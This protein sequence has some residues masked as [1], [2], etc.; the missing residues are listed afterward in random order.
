[1]TERSL[2]QWI[3][4]RRRGRKLKQFGKEIAFEDVRSQIGKGGDQLLPVF[5][6]EELK[7]SGKEM[8]EYR[9]GFQARISPPRQSVS[10]G[11]RTVRAH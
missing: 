4:M 3:F 5:S 1:L 8:E 2:I 7:R 6:E 9:G 10:A 11:T